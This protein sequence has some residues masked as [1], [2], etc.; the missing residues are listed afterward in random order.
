MSRIQKLV[1]WLH[2]PISSTPLAY[3]RIA[4]GSIMLW[5]VTRY[6]SK[7]WIENY[8][9]KPKMFF[10]YSGF[11]W[12]TPWEGFGMYLHF[13]ILGMLA[14][15]I[16]LGLFYRYVSIAF[17][18]AFS[19]VFLLD[20]SNY[21]NH[22]YLIVLLSG[23]NIF[24]P[25]N[26]SYSLDARLFPRLKSDYVPNWSLQ[27]V[28]FMLGVAYF[29][30]GVAKI[31]PDWFAGLPIGMWVLDSRDMPLV[32]WMMDEPWAKYFF[33]WS[34]LALDLLIVPALL[35]RKTRILGLIGI[36]LF[37]LWNSQ[38]FSIGI[39]PWFMI[40][41]TLLFLP[42]E[43]FD[44]IMRK[45]KFAEKPVYKPH[46]AGMVLLAVFV[47]WQVFWPLRHWV[48]DG[49]V[50]WNEA[51]HR[52]SWHMKLRTKNGKG[53]FFVV[54]KVTGQ[55]E[56][57]NMND[58]LT[59]RQKSKMKTHP[60]MIVQFGHYVYDYYK[61]Q[62]H[63]VRVYSDIRC[64]LN[65]RPYQDFVRQ[66]VNLAAITPGEAYDKLVIPLTTPRVEFN[67]KEYLEKRGE[68]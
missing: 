66:D 16:I 56:R 17:F 52:F 15:F 67:A 48:Y 41:A 19:Y 10:G 51:G 1:A 28:R 31:N 44:R 53:G 22:F 3:Y 23:I 26:R 43:F 57:V 29:F 59:R 13:F 45:K 61:Q 30:G 5:E 38:L 58:H 35:W 37:H 24:L 18:L 25:L 42:P 7:G 64:S 65:G 46:R 21:L 60:D 27:L 14:L 47:A 11:E 40:A 9:I 8:W 12:V 68:K 62:G 6:F 49:N 34:G 54:D 39:F 4:F 36:A 32:G 63:D 20:K 2:Q 50:H 55:S 33:A